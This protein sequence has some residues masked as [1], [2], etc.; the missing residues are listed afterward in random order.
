MYS[1][2]ILRQIDQRL[3]SSFH[4]YPLRPFSSGCRR[5]PYRRVGVLLRKEL[6]LPCSRER[7]LLVKLGADSQHWL[8]ELSKIKLPARVYGLDHHW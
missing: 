3:V 5:R 4:A 8:D 6:Q 7:H 1:A 2:L